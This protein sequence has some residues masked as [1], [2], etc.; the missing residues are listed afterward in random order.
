MYLYIGNPPSTGY[1]LE[2]KKNMGIVI[3]YEN[4]GD[5]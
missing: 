3:L 2:R 1:G 4:E 5:L